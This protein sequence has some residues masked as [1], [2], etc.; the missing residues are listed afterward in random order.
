[1]TQVSDP[2][3]AFLRI[4]FPLAFLNLLLSHSRVFI[5]FHLHSFLFSSPQ[6]HPFKLS[7]YSSCFPLAFP[8]SILSRPFCIL[9]PLPLPPPGPALLTT[10]VSY[11]TSPSLFLFSHSCLLL[12][13]TLPASLFLLHGEQLVF[14]PGRLYSQIVH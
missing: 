4:N 12:P 6:L 1:M 2:Q 7:P 8:T 9:L 13:P 10:P 14:K 11:H 3:Q 5:F